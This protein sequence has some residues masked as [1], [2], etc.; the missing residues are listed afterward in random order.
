MGIL[1]G[2]NIVK[3]IMTMFDEPVEKS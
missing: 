1:T 2:E 3:S